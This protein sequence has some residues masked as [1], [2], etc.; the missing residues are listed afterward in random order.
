[1]LLFTRP[2]MLNCEDRYFILIVFLSLFLLFFFLH[3]YHLFFYILISSF[4]SDFAIVAAFYCV[5]LL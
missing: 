5:S 4:Q 3:A 1:M 2:T